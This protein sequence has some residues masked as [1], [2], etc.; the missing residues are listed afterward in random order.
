[1]DIRVGFCA[2]EYVQQQ[3]CFDGIFTLVKAKRI[4][5]H[6][7]D[8][9]PEIVRNE[10][11]KQIEF[12]DRLLLSMCDLIVDHKELVEMERLICIISGITPTNRTTNSEVDMDFILS[13]RGLALGR[14]TVTDDAFLEDECDKQHHSRALL[15]GIDMSSKAIQQR[16][17]E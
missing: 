14:G 8:E 2:D 12:A 6:F 4:T 7:D 11:V 16:L 13:I 1:M 17:Y 5:Q 3:F 10:A 15:L 9:E